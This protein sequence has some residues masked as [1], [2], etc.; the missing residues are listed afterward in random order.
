MSG[1][2]AVVYFHMIGCHH[3]KAMRPA[4]EDAKKQMKG[5][6]VEEKE[7]QDVD[8]NDGVQGFPTIVVYRNGKEHKRLEGA[9]EQGKE[10]LTELGLQGRRSLRRNTHRRKRKTRH[11]TLRNYKALA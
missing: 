7:S 2:I 3:C 10:I 8:M 1:R 5:M 9:R 11:R 6:D 4:W